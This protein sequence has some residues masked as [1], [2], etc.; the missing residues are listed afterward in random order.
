MVW[1]GAVKVQFLEVFPALGFSGP[2]VLYILQCHLYLL[3]LIREHHRRTVFIT[4]VGSILDPVNL[5]P[6]GGQ[7]AKRARVCLSS[8]IESSGGKTTV[9]V[10]AQT[11]PRYRP[12]T[13]IR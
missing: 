1:C 2:L 8:S 11:V 7:L 9:T 13:S 6:P 3:Y 12:T 10:L 5:L 4:F